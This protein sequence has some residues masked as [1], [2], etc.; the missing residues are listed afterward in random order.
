MFASS[1]FIFLTVHPFGFSC[2]IHTTTLI[3]YIMHRVL[4]ERRSS[5]EAGGSM[6]RNVRKVRYK[7]KHYNTIFG[8]GIL[9]NQGKR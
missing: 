3:R 2:S 4:H 7:L 9:S 6:Q 1:Y 8:G 5:R